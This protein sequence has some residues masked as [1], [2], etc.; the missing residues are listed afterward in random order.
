[1]SKGYDS[2]LG[3]RRLERVIQKEILE[4]MA[5]QMYQPDWQ[6]VSA[7]RVA[8]TDGQVLFTASLEE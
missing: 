7:I 4:P 2:R 5:R 1:V 3:C 8:L 6:N